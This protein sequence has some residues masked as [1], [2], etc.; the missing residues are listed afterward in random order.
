MASLSVNTICIIR[1][2]SEHKKICAKIQNYLSNGGLFN[3]ELM[4]HENV[5]DMIIEIRDYLI[6]PPNSLD[7]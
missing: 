4:D 2:E 3:P 1:D 6:C 5:R 7:T